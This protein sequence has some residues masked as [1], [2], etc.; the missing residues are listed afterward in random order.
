MARQYASVKLSIWSD[1]EFRSLSPRAQHLY[2]VLLTSPSLSHCGIAD[3]RPA[4]I[5]ALAGNWTKESVEAA[6]AELV[7]RL[8]LV[9]DEATEEVLV[10]SFVR[11]DE[12]MKQ[13]K[14]A[15]SMANAHAAAASSVLRG[16]IVHELRR[17]HEEFPELHGWKAEAAAALLSKASI[18]P[19]TYPLG[20]GPA[21]GPNGSRLGVRLPQ[22]DP[23]TRPS[24]SGSD[25]GSPSPAPIPA[26]ASS[27]QH[28]AAATQRAATSAAPRRG[29]PRDDS[30]PEAR[31][32]NAIYD[33]TGGM[34]EWIAMRKIAKRALGRNGNPT[35]MAIANAF[36]SL[37]DLGKPIT[38]QTVG[39]H[40]DGNVGQPQ[41]VRSIQQQPPKG[42]GA[43]N[44]PVVLPGP[45]DAT[46][47]A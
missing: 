17:L 23:E 43:W 33:H 18:D 38:L 4:R 29:R 7:Q 41:N 25:N 5:A 30:S 42:G 14:M 10:R 31:I 44:R 26:P 39:Q 12:L 22:A 2:F 40:L 6:A 37:Y 32:A 20:G 28:L 13:P 47:V 15:V 36:T 46:G 21:G 34:V 1:D 9:V 19:S 16:V 27:N 3:W 24:G 35:E 11:H 8:Y 45:D